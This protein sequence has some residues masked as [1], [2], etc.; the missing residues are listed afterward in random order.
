MWIRVGAAGSHTLLPWPLALVIKKNRKNECLELS[1]NFPQMS[2]IRR[3]T[4]TYRV[5]FRL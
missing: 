2:C 5:Y 3:V 4:V 1:N